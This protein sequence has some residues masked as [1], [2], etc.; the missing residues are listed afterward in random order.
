MH[1]DQK[2]WTTQIYQTILNQK[3]INENEG[4]KNKLMFHYIMELNYFILK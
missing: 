4:L 1:E 2:G 3:R